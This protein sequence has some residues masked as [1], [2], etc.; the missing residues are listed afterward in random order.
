MH[1]LA[2]IVVSTNDVNWLRPC[3]NTVYARAGEIDLDVVIAD[4]ESKDGTSEL[5]R[6]EFSSAR[7]VPCVNRGFGHANNRAAMTCD[8]RYVLFLNP[9]TELLEGTLADL[10]AT[11]DARPDIG[12]ASVR[13]VTPDGAIYPTIRRFPNALRAFGEAIGCERFPALRWLSPRLL[14]Q[15]AYDREVD[16]D[17]LT[18][19]FMIVRTE[20]LL[21][22]GIFDE[23]F[24]MSSEEVDLAFRIRQAGWRVVHLP[25][26]TILHHV[27]MGKPLGVRMEAQYAFARQQYAHKH[28]SA[29]HRAIYLSVVKS[30]YRLRLAL[31]LLPGQ[32][33]YRRDAS[34]L[35]LRTLRGTQP[36]PYGEAPDNAVA[37]RS[38]SPVRDQRDATV[39]H[40][41][42]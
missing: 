21:G 5:I 38:P 37:P 3:L 36:P 6:D 26:V 1:D 13:Q 39:E 10:I 42:L 7:V 8:A 14:D 31:G 15:R 35:A 40:A 16:C 28:F 2:V 30:R 20:A 18:G 27:H 12:L 19:A 41:A 34:L 4:N 33:R 9:D 32:A 23:R 22:A 24:F 29:T 25:D 11:L 17:W